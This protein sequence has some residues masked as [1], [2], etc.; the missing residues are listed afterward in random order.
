[1][2]KVYETSCLT[3]QTVAILAVYI[4]QFSFFFLFDKLLS[5]KFL[6]GK[7][8]L[9]IKVAMTFLFCGGNR[10]VRC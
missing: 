3:V 9:E 10:N 8:N 4:S 1:M 2:K 6:R 5:C 7:S